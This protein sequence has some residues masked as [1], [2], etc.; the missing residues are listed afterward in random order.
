M[1]SRIAGRM[2]SITGAIQYRFGNLLH[3]RRMAAKGNARHARGQAEVATTNTRGYA[4]Y[5]LF[6]LIF[7]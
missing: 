4:S 7:K 1:P 6:T 3:A 2:N 5:V